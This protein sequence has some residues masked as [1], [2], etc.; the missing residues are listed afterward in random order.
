MYYEIYGG[1]CTLY[2]FLIFVLLFESTIWYTLIYVFF[3][4]IMYSILEIHLIKKYEELINLH[5][6]AH[7][8]ISTI[9]IYNSM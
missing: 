8:Y 3:I 4:Y 1:K 9:V 7:I 6:V 2:F 5:N